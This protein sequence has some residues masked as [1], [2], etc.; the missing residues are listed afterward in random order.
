MMDRAMTAFAFGATIAALIGTIAAIIA[1]H[2]HADLLG[3]V[4]LLMV[5]VVWLR[6]EMAND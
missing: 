3:H 1:D 4:T 5:A 2:P 6:V